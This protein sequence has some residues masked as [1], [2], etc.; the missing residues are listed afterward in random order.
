VNA[1]KVGGDVSVLTFNDVRSDS[2]FERY[3]AVES[4]SFGESLEDIEASTRAVRDRVLMR[5]GSI[6]DELVAGYCLMG[7]G[8]FF[9]GRA[10]PA[11]AVASV[12]VHPAWRRKGIAGALLR[13]LVDVCRALPTALAPLYASTTRLYRR[14]GW[15]V[16]DRTLWCKVRADALGRLHG[17]GR[18]RVNPNRSDVEAF[19][20]AYL[21]RFDGP[22]DRPEWWLEAHWDNDG[23]KEGRREYGWFEGERITGHI[24]F[25]QP[26]TDPEHSLAVQDLVA[27]TP[28]ALRGLFGFLGSHEAQAAEITLKRASIHMRELAFLLPDVHNLVSIEGSMCWMQRMIDIEAA[29]RTRGWSATADTRLDLELSDPCV[30]APARLVVEF[31]RGEASISPGGTGRVRCGIGVLSAWYSSRLSAR[32]AS[33]LSLLEAPDDEIELMD[34]VIPCRPTLEPDYF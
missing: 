4:D 15:E 33:R 12:F 3:L 29:M 7:V 25:R 30:D 13:D 5:A 23:K 32:D 26:H 34:A 11:Q 8:Q 24:T 19:R 18:A 31:A 16:G 21:C 20:R 14:Y 6:G 10:V 22:F 2:D 1:A 17:E 28:D 27:E 9:G